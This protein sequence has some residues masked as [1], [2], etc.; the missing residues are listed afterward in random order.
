MLCTRQQADFFFKDY[1]SALGK[2]PT[3][4]RKI[5]YPIKY[6]AAKIEEYQLFSDIE[7]LLLF[8]ILHGSKYCRD[9]A[10]PDIHRTTKTIQ[11]HIVDSY[12]INFKQI[13]KQ[14]QVL[15]YRSS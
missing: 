4:N 9:R 15:L 10:K 3:K 11:V 12:I 13:E 14:S 1:H 7:F 2:K 5:K 6:M 8:A